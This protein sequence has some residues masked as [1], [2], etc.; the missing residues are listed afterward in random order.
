MLLEVLMRNGTAFVEDT[1]R[2]TL[3]ALRAFKRTPLVACTIVSTV[4]LGLGLVAV[5]FTVLNVLLF[6]VDGVP[7]V[8]EMFAVGREPQ[9]GSASFTRA[10][11]DALR[12][13][14]TVFTDA[15]AELS[16]VDSIV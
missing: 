15:Y 13:E 16:D 14:T 11:F 2:D 8:H 1:V 4:G 7:D 12:R 5:A 10:Q 9:A 6:R 3:Y